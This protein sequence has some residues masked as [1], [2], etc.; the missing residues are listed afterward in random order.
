MSPGSGPSETTT[1]AFLLQRILKK[2]LARARGEKHGAFPD[3][4]GILGDPRYFLL[5]GGSASD[6]RHRHA[7]Q[8][9]LELHSLSTLP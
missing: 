1:E 2:S 8:K 5:P 4:S 9:L 6:H 7:G 3:L